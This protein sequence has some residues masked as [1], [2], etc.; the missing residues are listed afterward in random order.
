MKKTIF[1]VVLALVLGSIALVYYVFNKP[2]RDVDSEK[3]SIRLSSAD[4][5]TNYSEKEKVSD[6]LYLN[7]V[8]E[9]NGKIGDITQDQKGEHVL[10]LEGDGMF[11]VVCSMNELDAENK[12]KVSTLKV[13]DKVTLKG[14]CNGF[15][16]DVKLNKCVVLEVANDKSQS[17]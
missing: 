13:G 12:K 11:G 6:S 8:I 7:K 3:P 15:D 17:I 5:F 16:S 14:I 10:V 4:L 9:V 2:H 1:S